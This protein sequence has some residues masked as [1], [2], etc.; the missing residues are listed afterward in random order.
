MIVAPE[1]FLSCDRYCQAL[2]GALF[3]GLSFG[4]FR[5]HGAGGMQGSWGFGW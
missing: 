2:L 5:N 4:G 3:W 1:S